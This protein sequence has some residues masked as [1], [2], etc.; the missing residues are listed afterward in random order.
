MVAL[1]SAPKSNTAAD[2]KNAE[3][4]SLGWLSGHIHEFG[5]SVLRDDEGIA[6]AERE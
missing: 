4:Q 1:I 3:Q 2:R 5:D 6:R